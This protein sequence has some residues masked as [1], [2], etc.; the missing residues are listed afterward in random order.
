MG[1]N[2]NFGTTLAP[3]LQILL[4]RWREN[5]PTF[6]RKNMFYHPVSVHHRGWVGL[7]VHTKNN[8]SICITF[9]TMVGK[10]LIGDEQYEYQKELAKK[11]K[12]FQIQLQPMVTTHRKMSRGKKAR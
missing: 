2:K 3:T 11:F 6:L 8:G 10:G 5:R 4:G 12:D 7:A 1:K 9:A